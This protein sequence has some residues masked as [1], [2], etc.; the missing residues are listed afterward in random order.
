MFICFRVQGKC[1]RPGAACNSDMRLIGAERQWVVRGIT[2]IVYI[3]VYH[4]N[5]DNPIDGRQ[6]VQIVNGPSCQPSKLDVDEEIW[7]PI[8]PACERSMPGGA[9]NFRFEDLTVHL[10]SHLCITP[11]HQENRLC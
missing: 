5:S 9:P 7:R 2:Y 10:E 4:C 11:Q 8:Q 3:D 1:Q 6:V